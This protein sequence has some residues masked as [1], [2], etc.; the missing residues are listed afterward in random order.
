[1]TRLLLV[2]ALLALGACHSRSVPAV[3]ATKAQVTEVEAA[4]SSC[5]AA[6]GRLTPL[7]A[8]GRRT[9]L[10]DVAVDARNRCSSARGTI[11][12]VV[13]AIPALG[14]CRQ[15]ADAQERVSIAELA[16]LDASTAESRAAVVHAL[17]E[18]IGLQDRCG[19]VI[20]SL[21]KGG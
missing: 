16:V 8:Q 19:A 3:T 21:R 10:A 12:T 6:T 4:V 13:R 11:A 7:I 2:G 20:A 5:T 17:D 1:M 14:V 9:D 18:A 15:D